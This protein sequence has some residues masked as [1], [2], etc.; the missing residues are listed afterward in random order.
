[1]NDR[2]EMAETMIRA[3]R[4]CKSYQRA[5][6]T[7]K[8]LDELDLEMDAG[9]F[10]ALMGPSGSGKTTLLN[11][12]GGLDGADSGELIVAG[13]DLGSAD[14]AALALAIASS[15]LAAPAN[16]SKLRTPTATKVGFE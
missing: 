10:Y 7:L 8:V 14:P 1:M 11:L 5:G 9:G 6:E 12:I 15:S 3:R 2:S 4:L 13:E 16:G